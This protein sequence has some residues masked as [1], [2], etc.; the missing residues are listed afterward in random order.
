[1]ADDLCKSRTALQILMQIRLEEKKKTTPQGFPCP[2]VLQCF[3]SVGYTNPTF[4]KTIFLFFF[5]R[6]T[7]FLVAWPEGF[8]CLFV[9]L[10]SCVF[11]SLPGDAAQAAGISS[12]LPSLAGIFV[13]TDLEFGSQSHVLPTAAGATLKHWA[14]SQ[15]GGDFSFPLPTANPRQVALYRGLMFYTDL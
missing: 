1:M 12:A 3:N 11:G 6:S 14:G 2:Q 4:P 8:F 15:V 13:V 5:V 10:K 9:W 7:N